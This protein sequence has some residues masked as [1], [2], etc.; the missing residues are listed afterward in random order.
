[1]GGVKMIYASLKWGLISGLML[2]TTACDQL[3][4]TMGG[5]PEE[6]K[7][8][9]QFLIA[10]LKSPSS[11]NFLE[12]KMWDI[13]LKNIEYLMKQF[14]NL[15]S[16]WKKYQEERS[17]EIKQL[18]EDLS[19]AAT[20]PVERMVAIDYEAGNSFGAQIKGTEYCSFLSRDGKHLEFHKTQID[21]WIAYIPMGK[22]RCC[23][24]PNEKVR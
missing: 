5:Q 4:K 18:I 14:P 1:M 8:C 24:Q 9:E 2:T 20:S 13:E 22:T 12:Y 10:K 3:N 23:I 19:E 17:L 11:Y 7:V 15:K 6:V 16:P 21:L